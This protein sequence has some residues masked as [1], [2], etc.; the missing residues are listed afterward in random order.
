[1]TDDQSWLCVPLFFT[2][3]YPLSLSC[4][5]Y[6]E[7]FDTVSNIDPND[8]LRMLSLVNKC[9]SNEELGELATN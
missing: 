4:S 8:R 7:T 9:S 2:H 6:F 1:M 5:S 3:I